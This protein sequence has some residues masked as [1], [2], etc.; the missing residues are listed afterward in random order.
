MCCGYS[1]WHGR[2]SEQAVGEGVCLATYGTGGGGDHPYP[3]PPVVAREYS[4][5]CLK[6]AAFLF[7]RHT[8]KGFTQVEL[9]FT[10]GEKGAAHHAI[11]FPQ[12]LNGGGGIC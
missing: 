2:A 1:I 12:M 6:Q 8:L 4:A 9:S 10:G 3:V 5:Q 11:Y 7:G